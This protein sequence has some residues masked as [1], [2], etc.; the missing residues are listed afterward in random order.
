MTA[1]GELAMRAQ[2]RVIA[3]FRDQLGYTYLGNWHKRRDN[4]NIEPEILKQFLTR[5]CHAPN[6]IVKA[7]DKLK[8]AAAL[9]GS[10]TLYDANREVYDLLRYGAKVRPGVGEQTVTVHLIDWE[11]PTAN[12][13]AIAEEVTIK[14]N[15]TKRPDILLY[16][17]GIAVGILEHKRSTVSVA[18]GIR[19]K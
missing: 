8:N 10:R 6:L 18:E 17:N 9:G 5:Q 1:V 19:Q 11:D 14:G 2:K 3:L 12:D 7:I 13:F 16:V 4:R 15:S